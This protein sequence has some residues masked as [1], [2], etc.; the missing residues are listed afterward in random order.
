[1]LSIRSPALSFFCKP[2]NFFLIFLLYNRMF[3]SVSEFFYKKNSEIIWFFDPPPLYLQRIIRETT[4]NATIH[5]FNNAEKRKISAEGRIVP[6]PSLLTN[7]HSQTI[8]IKITS[9]SQR[10]VAVPLSAGRVLVPIGA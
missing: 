10:I 3:V 5:N 1:M 2:I 4:M 8:I 7:F 6:V 9:T